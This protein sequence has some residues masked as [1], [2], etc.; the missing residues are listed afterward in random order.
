MLESFEHAALRSSATIEAGLLEFSETEKTKMSAV[1][2][3]TI[4]AK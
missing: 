3:L 1:R 2:P 4:V